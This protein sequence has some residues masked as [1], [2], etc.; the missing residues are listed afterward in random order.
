MPWMFPP[1]LLDFPLSER[2]GY[3]VLLHLF[4]DHPFRGALPAPR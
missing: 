2:K 3:P 1:T 4:H